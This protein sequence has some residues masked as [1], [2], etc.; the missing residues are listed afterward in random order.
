MGYGAHIHCID[1][2]CICPTCERMDKGCTACDDCLEMDE[3][4]PECPRYK[5][6]F[7]DKED[8]IQNPYLFEVPKGQEE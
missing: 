7:E 1:G 3:Q 2:H 5:P 6:L 4:H 8:D